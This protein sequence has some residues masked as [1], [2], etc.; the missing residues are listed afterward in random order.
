[1]RHQTENLSWDEYNLFTHELRH[2]YNESLDCEIKLKNH[3]LLASKLH[4]LRHDIQDILY[5]LGQEQV[6]K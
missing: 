6:A 5:L 3:D 2:V 4:N 1:M